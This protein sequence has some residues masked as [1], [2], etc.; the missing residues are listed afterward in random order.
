MNQSLPHF[1]NITASGMV[2]RFPKRPPSEQFWIDPK[3]HENFWQPVTGA[4]SG[5]SASPRCEARETVPG[6]SESYNWD[7]QVGLHIFSGEVRVEK[8]PSSGKV[9]FAQIHAHGADN[10]F[11][12][13]T[14]W[15]G[16]ARIDARDEATGEARNLVKI[17]ARLSQVIKFNLSIDLGVLIYNLMG[18]EGAHPIHE[19]WAPY[20]FYDKRGAY[21]IDKDGTPDEGAWVV[22]EKSFVQHSLPVEAEQ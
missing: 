3:G 15:N 22:Y 13:V 5:S 7:P 18:N 21:C 4:A 16:Y 20:P 9:I 19:S 1:G 17:P 10:P 8:V 2:Y 6:T 11:L 12:M 14:W